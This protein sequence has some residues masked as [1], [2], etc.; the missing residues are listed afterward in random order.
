[1]TLAPINIKHL[2]FRQDS[3]REI[4]KAGL[5]STSPERKVDGNGE[6]ETSEAGQNRKRRKEI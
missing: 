5:R 4:G 3:T 2:S 6:A 1:M